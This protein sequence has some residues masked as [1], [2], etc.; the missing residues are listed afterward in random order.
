MLLVLIFNYCWSN[1]PTVKSVSS[2]RDHNLSYLL[3]LSSASKTPNSKTKFEDFKVRKVG[4]GS[5]SQNHFHYCFLTKLLSI[6]RK[7]KSLSHPE[8]SVRAPSQRIGACKN[9]Y[10]KWK[11]ENEPLI[12]FSLSTSWLCQTA[13][14]FLSLVDNTMWELIKAIKPFEFLIQTLSLFS[15]LSH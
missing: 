5:I 1:S 6:S 3:L 13:V 4:L 12:V 14:K 11:N 2:S 15:F 8:R 9:N 7:Q 10:F